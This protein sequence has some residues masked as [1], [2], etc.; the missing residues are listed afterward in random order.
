[1]DPIDLLPIPNSPITEENRAE[2]AYGRIFRVRDDRQKDQVEINSFFFTHI[3]NFYKAVS[4][5][6]I[7]CNVSGRWKMV[8]PSGLV[9]Q[10]QASN[11]RT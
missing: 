6:V 4:Y 3:V 10:L 8:L 11:Q 2:P 9:V 1:M 7:Q 5:C